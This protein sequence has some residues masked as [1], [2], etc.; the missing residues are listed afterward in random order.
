[1]LAVGGALAVRLVTF[2]PFSASRPQP[3]VATQT[4]RVAAS[5]RTESTILDIASPA[6]LGAL[7]IS[8]PKGARAIRPGGTSV[9]FSLPLVSSPLQIAQDSSSFLQQRNVQ[10]RVQMPSS[11]RLILVTLTSENDFILFDS[12]YPS[13]RDSPRLYRLLIGT[14][15]PNPL[16]LQLT[17]PSDGTFT[18]TLTVEFDTPLIGAA[19]GAGSDARVR[20][21]VRVVRSLGVKT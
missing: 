9:R 2:S 14:Y 13:I 3:L 19:V 11:P 5:G 10:L 4:I 18:L 1:L 21:R 17:L 12:S 16:P 15:P 6:P 8:E 7:S 20:T